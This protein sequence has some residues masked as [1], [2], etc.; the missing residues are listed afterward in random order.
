MNIGRMQRVLIT[1]PANA[2]AYATDDAIGDV[3]GSAINL[4]NGLLS[5]GRPFMLVSA[6]IEYHVAAVPA[7]SEFGLEF[8]KA[9]PTAIADN[10]AWSLLA[11]DAALHVGS[12]NMGAPVDRVGTLKVEVDNIFKMLPPIAGLG[13]YV[14]LRAKAGFTPAGNS[15]TLA[16][17]LGGYTV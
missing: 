4:F 9:S 5:T 3:G 2:T 6:A 14:I 11:A 13:L 7:S 16:I 15:E 10:A 8:Y 1:R 12:L 17:T